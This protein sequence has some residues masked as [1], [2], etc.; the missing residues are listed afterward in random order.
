MTGGGLLAVRPMLVCGGAG[1]VRHGKTT[2][3]IEFLLRGAT[4]RGEPDVFTRNDI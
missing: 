3:A 2:L 4:E 1:V